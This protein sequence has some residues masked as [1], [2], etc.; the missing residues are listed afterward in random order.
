VLVD[1]RS[2]LACL[3]LALEAE[4]QDIR[5]V[6]SLA[7]SRE[8]PHP[9]QRA[10]VEHGAI[11]CG[12][13]TPGMELAAVHLLTRNESP[14]DEE[15]RAALSGNLC[16]CTGYARIVVAIRE[17]ARAMREAPPKVG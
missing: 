4:G 9:V 8:E 10:F 16:R 11:Q 13:C 1:G 3:T 17:A 12:F 7:G 2:V 15:I 5:T 6:E 14:S